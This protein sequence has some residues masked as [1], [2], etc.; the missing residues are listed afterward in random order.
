MTNDISHDAYAVLLPAFDDADFTE[1]TR[2]FFGSGGVASLLGS[3]REEYVSRRMS[4]ER[5]KA[6]TAEQLLDYGR[7]ARALAGNVLITIDYEIGGVHRL[8]RHGPQLAHPTD[9]LNMSDKEIEAFG[10]A[11]ARAAKLCGINLFLAPIIDLMTG[12]NAWLQDR[13]FSLDAETVSRVACAFVRG[14]QAEGV[15]ATAKHFPGHPGM[16]ADPFDNA[17]VTL[18]A[19]REELAPNLRCFDAVI[20]QGVRAIMM[21]PIPVEAIDPVE[22]SSSSAK[23]VKLLK[24]THGFQGLLIS[25]DLDLPGTLR[26]RTVPDV[27]ITSLK[28]GVDLLLLASGPQIDEVVRHIAGAVEKGDLPRETLT[29]AANKVRKLAH[30][31][32]QP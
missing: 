2:S 13:T 4:P 11:A 19:T 17:T 15:A 29:R 20:A 3:T 7:R 5:Q 1:A 8:H 30:D 12:D 26:G 21:G 22:P 28:A 14:V 6:E 25:D 9:V 23:A 24:E 32:T 16:P 27:A 10:S 18:K 31:T